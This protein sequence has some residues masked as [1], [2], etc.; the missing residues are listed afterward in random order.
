MIIVDLSTLVAGNPDFVLERHHVNNILS[1][2]SKR[3]FTM[4]FKFGWSKFYGN[5]AKYMGA[6][7]PRDD[8]LKFP[9]SNCKII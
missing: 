5:P 2:D 3:N 4:I 7:V 8:N 1:V 9:G 6:A